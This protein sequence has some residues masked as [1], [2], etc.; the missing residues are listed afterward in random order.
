M[1]Q[2]L[3]CLE[4]DL[5]TGEIEEEEEEDEG[6]RACLYYR[7]TTEGNTAVH[8]LMMSFSVSAF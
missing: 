6:R 8:E 3:Y 1:Q 5:N 4:K 2:W 7:F